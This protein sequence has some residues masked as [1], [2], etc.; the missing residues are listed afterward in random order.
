MMRLRLRKRDRGVR[1]AVIALVLALVLS[2]VAL[3]FKTP[4]HASITE[5]ALHQLGSGFVPTAVTEV[6]NSNACVDVVTPM[7]FCTGNEFDK[8]CIPAFSE[9]CL[10]CQSDPESH[11]DDEKLV[12][13]SVRLRGLH[14]VFERYASQGHYVEARKVLGMALHLIQDF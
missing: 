4:D 3:G 11:F 14:D 2:G 8:Q 6:M 7:L 10:S 9:I 5:N 12:G 13:A 1:Q